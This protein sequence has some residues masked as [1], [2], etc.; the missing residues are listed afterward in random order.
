[1]STQRIPLH[2]RWT[3]DL[4]PRE[5]LWVTEYVSNGF[6]P[7][8]AARAIFPPGTSDNA[9]RHYGDR[10]QKRPAVQRAIQDYLQESIDRRAPKVDLSLERLEA[11]LDQIIRQGN[12]FERVKAIETAAKIRGHFAPKRATVTH[13]AGAGVA[14]LTDLVR[15]LKEHGDRLTP[16]DRQRLAGHVTEEMAAATECLRLLAENPPEAAHAAA[17]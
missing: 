2:R 5:I 15:T 3:R 13:V 12:V 16:E 8:L 11:D 7:V 6:R 1:M 10:V 9:I 4:F 14:S 17:H